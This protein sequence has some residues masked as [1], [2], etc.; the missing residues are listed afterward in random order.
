LKQEEEH[1]LFL[2]CIFA[3]RMLGNFL[4]WLRFRLFRLC[5]LFQAFLSLF[6]L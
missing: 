4:L 6:F 3:F 2:A 1:F 5:I